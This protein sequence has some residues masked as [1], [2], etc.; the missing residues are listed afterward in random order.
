MK[1]KQER[2]LDQAIREYSEIAAVQLLGVAEDAKK[3]ATD[4]QIH[5]SDPY[6]GEGHHGYI[7]QKIRDM[8]VDYAVKASI[9]WRAV[10]VLA[11][12]K[13][14]SKPAKKRKKT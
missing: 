12:I 11:N 5:W 10:T 8:V 3:L 14:R 13:A 4:I 2:L 6:T 7:D 9:N 1:T